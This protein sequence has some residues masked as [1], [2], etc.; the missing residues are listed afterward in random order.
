MPYRRLRGA[1]LRL[2][3]RRRLAIAI[4]LALAVPSAWI[5]WTG[6]FGA[7]WAEGLA[8]VSGATG[9]ALIWTGLA[10]IPPDWND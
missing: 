7:W 10:G 6:R 2:A 8:L 5:E 4:G 3:R 9:I 1:I